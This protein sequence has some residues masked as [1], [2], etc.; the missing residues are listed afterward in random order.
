ML[1]VSLAARHLG[2]SNPPPINGYPVEFEAWGETFHVREPADWV[3]GLEL[4]ETAADIPTFQA[5]AFRRPDQ[6][7]ARILAPASLRRF[8]TIQ[9]ANDAIAEFATSMGVAAGEYI[10]RTI[11]P[12]R[13][14]RA[15]R[16]A[17]DAAFRDLISHS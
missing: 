15:E 17:V 10:A 9:P 14:P 4:P 8:L 6:L 11:P 16:E 7:Y 13:L 2:E 3:P 12:E 1:L 5:A